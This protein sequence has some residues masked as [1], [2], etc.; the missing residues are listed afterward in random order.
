MSA[1][2]SADVDKLKKLIL[3]NPFILTLPEVGNHKDEVIPKNVQQF[4]ISC[5]AND[6]LLYILAM[7]K[8]ELVQKKV[9]IFT[10]NIDTSFRL[11]LF[12]EK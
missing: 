4:W 2:S 6:K 8:L 5:A 9:L 11:K 12:L 7:L 10:N 3:H 1:T